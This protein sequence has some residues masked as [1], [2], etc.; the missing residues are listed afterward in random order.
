M[1]A[2]DNPVKGRLKSIGDSSTLNA[3]TTIANIEI[4]E[5][6]TSK[7]KILRG[8]EGELRTSIGKN[9]DLYIENGFIYGFTLENQK[10]Y[11]SNLNYTFRLWFIYLLVAGLNLG[12][13]VSCSGGSRS[14]EQYLLLSGLLAANFILIPGWIQIFAYTSQN[15]RYEKG[16][17]LPNAIG[18]D[19]P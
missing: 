19:V 12:A 10:S 3:I 11:Y 18:I 15:S 16:R 4:G 7:I 13:L 14:S 5:F 1:S 9:I 2:L 6:N 17:Q 8:L